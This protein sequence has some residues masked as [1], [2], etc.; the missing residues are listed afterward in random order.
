MNFRGEWK[1]IVI[2]GTVFTVCFYLPVGTHRFDNAV[3][4]A[5]EL[6]KW[7]A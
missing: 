1:K 4:E 5:L 2:V 7:Y 3:I 6:V